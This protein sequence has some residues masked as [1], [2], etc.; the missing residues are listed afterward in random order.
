[1]KSKAKK[2]APAKKTTAKKAPSSGDGP[3]GSPHANK[4][5]GT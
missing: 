3:L 4:K 2:G 1:M 5:K